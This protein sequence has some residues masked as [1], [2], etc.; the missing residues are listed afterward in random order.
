MLDE[1]WEYLQTAARLV[2]AAVAGEYKGLSGKR[3]ALIIGALIYF[4]SPVDIIPDFIPIAGLVEDVIVV[5]LALRV[6]LRGAGPTLLAE[7][8][9]GP[10][11]SLAVIY[12]LAY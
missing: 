1:V 4:A 9:P 3:L 6:V 12:R 2:Q 11:A 7:H 8:W 10:R 5:V